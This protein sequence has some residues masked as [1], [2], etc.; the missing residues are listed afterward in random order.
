MDKINLPKMMLPQP[1]R[2]QLALVEQKKLGMQGHS[3]KIKEGVK[4]AK[5]VITLTIMGRGT[6]RPVM[7]LLGQIFLQEQNLP[8][9]LAV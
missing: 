7:Q 5:V 4:G 2:H 6:A 3:K 1:L 8:S 9:P